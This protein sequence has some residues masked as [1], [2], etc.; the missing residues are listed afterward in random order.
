M[1]SGQITIKD[2]ART[3]NISPSTVSRA[4]K[5][6][7][8]ISKD[9]KKAVNELAAK[10][11]YQPNSIALSLRKSKTNTIGVIIPEMVHHFFS[12]VISGIEDVAYD[13]G[14][15]VMICQSNE[16]YTREVSNT[17]A[18]LSSR[19]DGMLI[20]VS[21]ETAQFDH[22]ENLYRKNMPLVFFDRAYEGIDVSKVVVDDYDGAYRATEHLIKQGCRNIYHLA[23]PESLS[24]SKL[25]KDGYIHALEAYNQPVHENHIV[26][27]GL[28]RNDGYET[29]KKMIAEGT[30]PDAIF[31]VSDPVAIGAILAYREAGIPVPEKVA[32]VGFSDEP[33]TSVIQPPLTTMAQPGYEM[34]RQAA[35]LLLKRMKGGDMDIPSE[36]VVLK[37]DL[38]IRESTQR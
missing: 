6:H 4:L 26:P 20:S 34:G 31:A 13:E 16:S 9:T 11:D 18:L 21:R 25:R 23:G 15:N 35:Q 7:P 30:I 2:I 17:A 8:D 3:L 22:L 33:I 12:S 38:K 5:D 32:I 29:I 10:L 14:Y 28:L 27:C 24:I 37:T 36:T 19:V 1:K